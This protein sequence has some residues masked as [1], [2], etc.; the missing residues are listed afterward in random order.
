MKERKDKFLSNVYK[1]KIDYELLGIVSKPFDLDNKNQK[2]KIEI[3][4]YW[5]ERCS[6]LLTKD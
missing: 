5:C 4:L 6:R 2:E 3:K 1:A